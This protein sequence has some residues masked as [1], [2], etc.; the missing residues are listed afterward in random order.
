MRKKVGIVALWTISFLT[1][2][3]FLLV[4]ISFAVEEPSLNYPETLFA[5]HLGIGLLSAGSGVLAIGLSKDWKNEKRI[6]IV[7]LP[8]GL[9]LLLLS[10][11]LNARVKSSILPLYAVEVIVLLL[12]LAPPVI[13]ALSHIDASSKDTKNN[14]W[15]TIWEQERGRVL[16]TQIIDTSRT[17]TAKAKMGS[18]LARGVVGE[19][20]FGPIGGIAGVSTAKQRVTEKS[21][22]SFLVYYIDGTKEVKI[23]DNGSKMCKIYLSKLDE[24]QSIQ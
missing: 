7:L 11:A 17:A 24:S 22:I 18:A 5:P 16:K 19:F 14:K 20:V 21:T 2:I 15:K 9:L 8:I 23:V 3:V 13:L 1:G 10:R 4:L 6:G 12:V